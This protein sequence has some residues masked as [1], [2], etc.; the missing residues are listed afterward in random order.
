M[1]GNEMK[2]IL[3]LSCYNFLLSISVV[4]MAKVAFKSFCMWCQGTGRI[5]NISV[6]CV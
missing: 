5:N 2:I 6:N 3:F 1:L 4:F